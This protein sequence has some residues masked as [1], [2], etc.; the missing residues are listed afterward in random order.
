[1]SASRRVV[2][3]R[4]LLDAAD[5]GSF[6]RL[7]A[8]SPMDR[9]R[10]NAAA[11]DVLSAL[12]AWEGIR[13]TVTIDKQ[14]HPCTESYNLVMGLYTAAGMDAEAMEVFRKMVEEGANPNSMTYTVIME[15][16][17]RAG[18]LENARQVFDQLE[19]MRIR[20]HVEAVQRAG[21]GLLSR[22][23]VRRRQEA[24]CGDA[25][26]RHTQVSPR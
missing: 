4:S 14:R 23:E 3:L 24:A 10:W 1:L 19:S 6:P 21:R 7:L 9:L 5:S 15:H 20:R 17:V 18:K 8:P 12:R 26:R 25:E 22:R 16:L 11:G 2:D 13:A